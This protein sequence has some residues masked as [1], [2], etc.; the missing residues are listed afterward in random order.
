MDNYVFYD[1][2]KGVQHVKND[3]INQDYGL[4]KTDS[5]RTMLIVSDG[6]GARQHFRSHIGAKIATEVLQQLFIDFSNRFKKFTSINE[7]DKEFLKKEIIKLWRNYTLNHFVNNELTDFEKQIDN[8]NEFNEPYQFYGTT[9]LG[10]LLKKDYMVVVQIGDGNILTLFENNKLIQYIKKDKELVA[11]ETTS[12]C[13]FN[14]IE[15]INVVIVKT[16]TKPVLVTVST[17]GVINSFTNPEDFYNIP[18]E[19]VNEIKSSSFSDTCVNVK[20]LLIDM[21][22]KGSGDDCTLSFLYN[23]N[24]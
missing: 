3:M 19:I 10:V 1:S 22:T 4:A 20:Q 9:L 8:D 6:H 14:A 11:N 23:R 21:A 13:D 15:N 7:M 18:Y 5:Y 16:K 17:D 2:I 12:L 24:N